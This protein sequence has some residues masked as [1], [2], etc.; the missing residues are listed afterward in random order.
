M[1]SYSILK[2]TPGNLILVANESELVGIY[3]EGFDHIPAEKK[4]WKLDP[5]HPVLQ[6]AEKQLTEYFQGKRS[7]FTIPLGFKGTKFQESVWKQIARI[8]FGKTLSYSDLARK[9]GS[10]RAIRAAGT[11]TGKNPLAIVIP[12]HR[13]LTKS[14][15]I[16]GF[17]GGLDWKR[18]LLKVENI[19][20]KVK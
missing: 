17:A 18:H 13:V 8:P 4:T 16:G 11:N 9:A 14:G 10:P 12:C 3:F 5:K 1:K 19:S 2:T 7:E 15:G 6:K 20:T